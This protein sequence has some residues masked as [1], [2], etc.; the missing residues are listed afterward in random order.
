MGLECVQVWD[1]R[2]IIVALCVPVVGLC[3]GVAIFLFQRALMY[4]RAHS[5]AFVFHLRVRSAE[6]LF[7]YADVDGSGEIDETEFRYLLA[8]VKIHNEIHNEKARRTENIANDNDRHIMRMLGATSHGGTLILLKEA[9]LKNVE[10]GKLD[11][12]FGSAWPV[13]VE[14]IQGAREPSMESYSFYFSCTHQSPAF[15]LLSG[16]PQYRRSRVS[17]RGLPS[18]VLAA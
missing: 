1:Y 13:A 8:T 6:H 18:R 17:T 10:L 11:S 15:L 16:L 12:I 14:S 4:K 3:L 5:K 7:S 2:G 9:F